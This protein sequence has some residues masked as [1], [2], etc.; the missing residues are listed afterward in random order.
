MVREITQ[1][2]DAHQIDTP[3][4]FLAFTQDVLRKAVELQA[5]KGTVVPKV[6]VLW[7]GQ[8][9]KAWVNYWEGL[10]DGQKV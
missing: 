8:K 5:V 3:E 10:D 4:K 6:Q 9:A 1:I 2:I 7:E